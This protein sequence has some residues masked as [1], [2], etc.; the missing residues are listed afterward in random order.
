MFAGATRST[1]QRDWM[2]VALISGVL[3]VIFLFNTLY[4]YKTAAAPFA[5][6]KRFVTAWRAAK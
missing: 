2:A 3:A 1:Y 5:W 6:W 4:I